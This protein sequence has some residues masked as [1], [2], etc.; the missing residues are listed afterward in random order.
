MSSNVTIFR[1]SSVNN[2]TYAK[3]MASKENMLGHGRYSRTHMP[4]PD[5]AAPKPT[6]QNRPV[7]EYLSPSLP[8][9]SELGWSS[10]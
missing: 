4:G 2:T 10:H 9:D 7:E 5:K 6:T 1:D 3:S 8:R